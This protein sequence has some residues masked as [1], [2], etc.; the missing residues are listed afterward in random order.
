MAPGQ[1]S[2]T[3]NILHDGLNSPT[4]ITFNGEAFVN[5]SDIDN[6]G[7]PN[8][9]DNCPAVANPN[10]QDPDGD[11]LGNVCDDDDDG[12]GLTDYEEVYE[13]Q[14]NPLLADTCL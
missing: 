10:Q 1:F 11:N 6:D 4:I 5:E 7:V 3:A 13:Y 12:D 8:E 9:E 2:Y 14:T